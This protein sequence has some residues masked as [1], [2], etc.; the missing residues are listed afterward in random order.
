MPT[1]ADDLWREDWREVTDSLIDAP[2]GIAL[3]IAVGLSA[4][5][6]LIGLLWM[7]LR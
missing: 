5:G 6:G 2:T 1:T 4:W 3:G 7:L